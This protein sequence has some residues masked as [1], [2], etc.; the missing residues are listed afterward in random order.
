[1]ALV[2]CG[3]PRCRHQLHSGDN[4]F[5]FRLLQSSKRLR[6]Q[7]GGRK[8]ERGER[9]EEEKGGSGGGESH[10]RRREHSTNYLK[11]GVTGWSDELVELLIDESA[12]I[13]LKC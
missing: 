9:Q 6:A 11:Q 12:S 8:R 10:G 5:R 2:Q 1:M 3:R 4:S 7:E 13:T